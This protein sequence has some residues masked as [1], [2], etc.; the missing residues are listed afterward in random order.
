MM[1]FSIRF[2]AVSFL[3]FF[4]C[5]RNLHI[6]LKK[7]GEINPIYAKKETKKKVKVDFLRKISFG[8]PHK[9]RNL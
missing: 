5:S 3:L 4:V 9:S 2:F 1:I 8:R 7:S 6:F